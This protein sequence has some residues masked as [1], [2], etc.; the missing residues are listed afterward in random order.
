M[1]TISIISVMLLPGCMLISDISESFNPVPYG[2]LYTVSYTSTKDA[3]GNLH[4]WRSQFPMGL[5]DDLNIKFW[6]AYGDYRNTGT[7]KRYQEWKELP[8]EQRFVEIP[9]EEWPYA[10]HN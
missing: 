9:K 7:W 6:N 3:D 4:Y 2:G 5:L 10:K 8:D 1:I